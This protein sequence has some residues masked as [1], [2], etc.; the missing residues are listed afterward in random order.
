MLGVSSQDWFEI[1]AAVVGEG[2][3]SRE[4]LMLE[5]VQ[6]DRD[7][8]IAKLVGS[9]AFSTLWRASDSRAVSPLQDVADVAS[10]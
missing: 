3:V 9:N 5:L 4:E 2:N 10:T 8:K 7:G 1:L 6:H